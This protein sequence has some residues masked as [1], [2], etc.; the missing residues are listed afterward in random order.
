MS[1]ELSLE[2]FRMPGEWESQKSVWIIWPYNKKDWPG[3]FDNIPEVVSKII[4]YLSINQHVNLLIRNH[5]DGIKIKMILKKF[6]HKISNIK[7]HL[8]PTNRIWVRD[9]GPIF[10]INDKTNSKIIL[11]F[12]F[13]GW[14]K[15]KDFQKDD[16]I[17]FKISK[18]TQIKKIEPKVK[19]KNKLKKIV[20]EGGAIDVNGQGSIILTKECLLSK[21]QER[22]P[23]VSKFKLEKVLNKYLNVSNFIW[24][25]KGIEG[26]D[27]HGHV[28]DISRF[29]SKNTIMTAIEKNRNFKNYKNLK[30]NL[31]IL[32]NSKNTNGKKFKIIEI[33]MPKPLS[34]NNTKVPASYLNFY[35]ANK[36]VL[37]PVFNDKNDKKVL[38]IFKKFF[39]SRKIIPIDC[40]E[41]IWGFG[42]IHCMTQQEP[43]VLT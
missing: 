7:F 32:K 9:S 41:L 42:A 23:G 35:I 43:S 25:N 24:L 6:K 21:I 10:L 19:I 11:N 13:N 17:N 4:S 37:L 5:K 22:N 1:K 30:E 40:S 26:D 12:K 20:L 15:Y 38:L 16:K 39:K 36:I 2:G 34:V 33:P 3:L 18:I 31:K 27:T 14:A 8:I 29:V 28:D